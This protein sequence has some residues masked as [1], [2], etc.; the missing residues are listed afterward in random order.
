MRE[1]KKRVY[2]AGPIFGCSDDACFGWRVTAKRLLA[3]VCQCVDP[4][5]RDYRGKE[6]EAVAPIVEGDLAAI[7]TCDAILAMATAPSW[8]TAMEIRAAYAIGKPVVAVCAG[9]VS[10]WL[11]YH[12]TVELSLHAACARLRQ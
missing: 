3:P 2:L 12:A 7:Q 8:G 1:E 4:M 10:P 11:A 5:L 6:L 9:P